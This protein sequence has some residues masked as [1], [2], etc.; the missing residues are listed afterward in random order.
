M[1]WVFE[2]ELKTLKIVGQQGY[3]NKKQW[4]HW[5]FQEAGNYLRIVSLGKPI[6]RT[7][8]HSSKLA[9][10][11]EHFANVMQQFMQLFL[12]HFIYSTLP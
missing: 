10:Q 8:I 3:R 1:L 11:I 4:I 5:M 12:C 6:L 2:A 7:L 9:G